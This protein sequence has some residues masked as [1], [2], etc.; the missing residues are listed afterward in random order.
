[1][2]HHTGDKWRQREL[3]TKPGTLLLIVLSLV[4]KSY[5]NEAHGNW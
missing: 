5:I 4:R 3:V 1:M 2:D